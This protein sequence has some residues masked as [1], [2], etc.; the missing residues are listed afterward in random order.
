MKA[1]N[2]R[3]LKKAEVN[4]EQFVL[5]GTPEGAFATPSCP[6]VYPYRTCQLLQH[7]VASGKQSS[8]C[9]QPSGCGSVGCVQPWCN[10]IDRDAV[11][12][13]PLLHEEQSGRQDFMSKNNAVESSKYCR[14]SHSVDSNT[15]IPQRC[16]S[17]QNKASHLTSVPA[18]GKLIND[19]WQ[20]ASGFGKD[21]MLNL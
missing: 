13:E 16:Q 14:S 9:H 12:Q 2:L 8:F 10:H 6:R 17:P 5:P 20:P 21:R 19:L 4:L 15:F 11:L 3:T 18:V 1:L 7:R